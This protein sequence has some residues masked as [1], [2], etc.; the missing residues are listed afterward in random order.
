[1]KSKE[2]RKD[3]ILW[4]DGFTVVRE[5]ADFKDLINKE[6]IM[7][8]DTETEE[9]FENRIYYP[10]VEEL[11]IIKHIT[12]RNKKTGEITLIAKAYTQEG[13]LVKHHGPIKFNDEQEYFNFI[14]KIESDQSFREEY[15]LDNVD[16]RWDNIDR[17]KIDEKLGEEK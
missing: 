16:I 17:K 6:W 7:K 4:N 3:R 1:M 8:I 13:Q 15:D 2:K 14:E 11:E 5:L 10:R 12:K 9:R